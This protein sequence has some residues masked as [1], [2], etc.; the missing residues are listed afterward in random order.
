MK[1]K[2]MGLLLIT[3][4]TYQSNF[5][6][7]MDS[8]K[9]NP[10]RTL[11]GVLSLF[12]VGNLAYESIK[13]DFE[14][15]YV[16]NGYGKFK[17]NKV[18]SLIVGLPLAYVI[19]TKEGFFNPEIITD[20]VVNITKNYS[21]LVIPAVSAGTI[22]LATDGINQAKTYFGKTEEPVFQIKDKNTG[23]TETAKNDNESGD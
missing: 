7:N 16:Y 1:N 15:S 23:N 14:N 18:N 8:I 20:K 11:F 13:A 10:F 12:L 17:E 21:N 9:N 2:I 5:A 3:M 4:V 22:K 6:L 19:A